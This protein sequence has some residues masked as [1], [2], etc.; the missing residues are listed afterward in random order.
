MIGII[1]AMAEEITLFKANMQV[2]RTETHAGMEYIVGQ[3][4]EQE[5][6]LLQ[7]G[8]GKV[9]AT[10]GTQVMIDKFAVETII[11]TGLAGALVPNLK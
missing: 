5:V 11:F 7:A 1:G 4:A 9:K 3:L 6:V 2:D 8:I 10:I